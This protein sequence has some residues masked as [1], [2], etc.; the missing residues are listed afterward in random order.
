MRR[1]TV[2]LGAA[3]SAMLAAVPVL[4]QGTPRPRTLGIL[5]HSARPTPEQAARHP[6]IQHLRELGWIE[7]HNLAVERAYADGDIGKLAHLASELVAKR[8]DLI[9]A[10]APEGA[11]AAARVTSTIPIVFANATFPVE[12]GLIDS[13]ARPGRN[14]TGVT[15][16]AYVDQ[17][18]KPLE[19]LKSIAPSRLRLASIWTPDNLQSVD[20][21]DYENYEPW[22]SAVRRLGYDL[23][24]HNVRRPADYEREFA[25][26]VRS[27]AEAVIALTT[28]MNWQARKQIIG[29][30]NRH[31]LASAFDTKAHV[32]AG[33]LVSYGPDVFENQRRS[34]YH[35]DKILRGAKPSDLPVEQPD[36]YELAVNLQTA[37]ALGL[38]IPHSVLIRADRV[39]E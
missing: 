35:V 20:G 28:P 39:I 15:Y 13:L 37:K 19:V 36:K 3:A 32:E 25:S 5:S 23:R 21:K 14:L 10:H 2:V 18:A 30:A 34:A 22:E 4:A 11:V 29:F 38:T 24:V 33:G 26:I 27:R 16:Y 12:L 7:G 8:V 31:R 9:W 17:G 1:R 6:M